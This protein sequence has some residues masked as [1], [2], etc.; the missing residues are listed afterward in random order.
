VA[1]KIKDETIPRKS[2]M[3]VPEGAMDVDRRR[4]ERPSRDRIASC[5]ASITTSPTLTTEES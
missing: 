1:K 3:G 4:R 2:G 5:H